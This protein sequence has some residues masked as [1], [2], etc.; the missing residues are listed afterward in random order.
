MDAAMAM[1][2]RRVDVWF[3]GVTEQNRLTVL[4]RF[5][6]LIPQFI[7]LVFLALA[8][9]FVAIIGWFAALI[10]GRLPEWAHT[11]MGGVVRWYV[12][13]GLLL[14]HD[15]SIPTLLL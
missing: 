5:I 12:R 4:V 15:R 2:S 9:L 3:T 6:L 10:T 14:P 8:V 1:P 7:I 13:V 11:F